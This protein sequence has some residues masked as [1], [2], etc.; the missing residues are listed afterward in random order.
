MPHHPHVWPKISI[1]AATRRGQKSCCNLIGCVNANVGVSYPF[2]IFATYDA[3]FSW[4]KH[5]IHHVKK[6]PTLKKSTSYWR[7]FDGRTMEGRYSHRWWS[8][9]NRRW[10]GGVSCS[11]CMRKSPP[12]LGVILWR[13]RK[14]HVT[15]VQYL[16]VEHWSPTST[17]R[18]IPFRYFLVRIEK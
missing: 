3:I 18:S 12:L 6:W 15:S 11:L 10:G 14:S 1:A 4:E 7:F 17:F 8:W 9:I 2:V 16:L 13:G 5:F